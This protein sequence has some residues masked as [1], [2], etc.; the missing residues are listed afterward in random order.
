M[1]Y[2]GPD[3]GGN[4]L[5]LDKEEFRLGGACLFGKLL[6]CGQEGRVC[7]LRLGGLDS[8]GS[9]GRGFDDGESSYD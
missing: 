2:G 1:L 5:S 9:G 6:V 8:K 4:G 7:V 3:F